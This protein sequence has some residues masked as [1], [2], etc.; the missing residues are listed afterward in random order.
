MKI[1]ILG[2][3]GLLGNAVGKYFLNRYG[4][5]NIF[6]TYRNKDFCYGR[7]KKIIIFSRDENKQYEM[8]NS[9][10][11]KRENHDNFYGNY[12]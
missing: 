12:N 11:K 1:L 2:S 8:K 7:V 9:F 4:E 3:T 10:S 6:L 5:E